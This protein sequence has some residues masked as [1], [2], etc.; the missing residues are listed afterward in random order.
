MACRDLPA[1]ISVTPPSHGRSN[2]DHKPWIQKT[3]SPLPSSA[4]TTSNGQQDGSFSDGNKQ[5]PS[6]TVV[7]LSNETCQYLYKCSNFQTLSLPSERTCQKLKTLLLLQL[8]WQS[9]CSTLQF[10]KCLS[11]WQLWPKVTY[12]AP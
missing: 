8:L 3:Q 6:R 5:G 7:C 10:K 4:G 2:F 1:P 11:N 12:S 9:S